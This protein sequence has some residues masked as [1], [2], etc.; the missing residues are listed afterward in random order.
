MVTD[1]LQALLF[2]RWIRE[3]LGSL[4]VM[5]YI[6]SWLFLWTNLLAI[7][8]FSIYYMD[9]CINHLLPILYIYLNYIYKLYNI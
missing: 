9:P 6:I 7:Y 4:Q 2:P 3:P 5:N 1:L 8:T